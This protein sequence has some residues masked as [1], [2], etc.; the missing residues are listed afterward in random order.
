[1]PEEEARREKKA[2][3]RS[4]ASGVAGDGG[5]SWL[6]RAYQRC[7]EQASE[8]GRSL[9]D[10]AAERYGVSL[11][12]DKVGWQFCYICQDF[13]LGDICAS[14]K[15]RY[16]KLCVIDV[17]ESLILGFEAQSNVETI[18]GKGLYTT[19]SCMQ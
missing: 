11:P 18:I 16:F 1:M 13:G 17:Q 5:A 10:I 15:K 2:E 8:E 19:A 4:T 3:P 7:I 14:S 9:E 6:R 12:L